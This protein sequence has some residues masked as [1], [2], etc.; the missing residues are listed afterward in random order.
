M[1]AAV[2]TGVVVG[3]V[4]V[5]L[6]WGSLK[7]CEVT[8]GTATCG[9]GPGLLLLVVIVVVAALLGAALLRA[10]RVNDPGS[11]SFLGVALLTVVALLFLIDVLSSG[12]MIVVIPLVAAGTY[13]LAHWVTTAFVEPG[14]R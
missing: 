8:R 5:G 12:W 9:G 14:G 11:T 1:T 3:L 13:A 2:L 7:G 10:F 6:T 4:T